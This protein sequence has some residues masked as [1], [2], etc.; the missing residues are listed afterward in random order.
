MLKSMIGK[1][2][3]IIDTSLSNVYGPIAMY[4]HTWLHTYIHTYIYILYVR[5]YINSI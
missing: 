3:S 5:N 4:L 1:F 2:R